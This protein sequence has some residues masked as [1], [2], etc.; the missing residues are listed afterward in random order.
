M[1]TGVGKGVFFLAVLLNCS[2]V[3]FEWKKA[4]VIPT[5]VSG[6]FRSLAVAGGASSRNPP[7]CSGTCV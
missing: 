4:A 1:R 6:P 3:S 7:E 5:D 2:D